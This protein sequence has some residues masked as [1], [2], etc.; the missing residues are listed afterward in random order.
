MERSIIAMILHFLVPLMVAK[1]AWKENWFRPL[2]D[3]PKYEF[4][5]C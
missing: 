5:L 2:P 1:A 4:T 3:Y